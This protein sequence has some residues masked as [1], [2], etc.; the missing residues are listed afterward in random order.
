M[1]L[2]NLCLRYN[3][4]LFCVMILVNVKFLLVCLLSV[5]SLLFKKNREDIV[6]LSMRSLQTF[7]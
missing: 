2:K 1:L 5:R 6:L 7:V 4:K 3:L